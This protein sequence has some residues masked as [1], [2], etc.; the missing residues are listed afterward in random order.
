MDSASGMLASLLWNVRNA[1]KRLGVAEV[2]HDVLSGS[3]GL[4]DGVVVHAP[5]TS[6]SQEGSHLHTSRV[7]AHTYTLVNPND[8]LK[9]ALLA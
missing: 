1:S 7:R 6:C 8:T 3:D 4:W 9:T 2:G 5:P